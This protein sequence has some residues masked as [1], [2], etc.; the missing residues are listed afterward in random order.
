MNSKGFTLIE[1]LAVLLIVGIL[2]AVGVHKFIQL[3]NSAANVVL[4]N[5]VAQFNDTEKHHWTN[6]KLSETYMSDDQMFELVKA[7]LIVTYNWKEI[8][9]TGGIVNINTHTFKV[10]RQSSTQKGYAIWKE[11]SSGG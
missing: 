2:T 8:S 6:E 10:V 5:A 3:D 4:R 7:D 1:I 9:P 11:V